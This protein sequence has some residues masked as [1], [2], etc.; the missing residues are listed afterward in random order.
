MLAT[1]GGELP[2]GDGW[3]YEVKWDGY[4]TLALK[5]S[6]RVQLLSRSLSDATAHYPSITSAIGHAS[7][8]AVLLDGEAVAL[9][10]RGHPSFQAHVGQG[11]SR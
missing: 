9:D 10:E 1:P 5:D 4:R 8:D 3:T 2:E 6:G 11:R 7:A